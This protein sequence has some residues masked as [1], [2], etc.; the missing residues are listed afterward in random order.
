MDFDAAIQCITL[1]LLALCFIILLRWGR[2]MAT[3]NQGLTDLQN[4]V[5]AL[6]AGISAAVAEIQAQTAAILAALNSGGDSDAAVEAAA[7]AINAQATV[8]GAAV[9]AAQA[10]VPP[11]PQV[12]TS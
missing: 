10:P 2:Q 7:Q 3:Q 12:K 6:T 1:F 4:A 5:T 8:L 11:A 9:T